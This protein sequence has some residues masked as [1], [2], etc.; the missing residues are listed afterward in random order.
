M[1]LNEDTLQILKNFASINSNMVFDEG[2]TIKTISEAKNILSEA[3]I[4]ESFPQKFGV[5]DLNEFLGVLGLVDKPSLRFEK[6]YSTINDSTGR[7]KVKYFFSDTEMLTTPS[8]TITMPEADVTFSL[9]ADTLG[10]IR[11][12]AGALGHKELKVEPSGGAVSLTVTSTE[13]STAN[14]FSIDVDGN[15]N[16][17]KYNF[18]FNISNLKMLSGDYNVE[19]SKKLISKFTNSQSNVS[20]WIALEK[21]STYGV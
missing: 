15:A 5:Y 2:N 12:A 20:Y 11:R 16:V 19:I 4:S 9:D 3:T 13:N 8:K 6:D 21:T 18:I 17:D 7:S 1:E 14:T 10:K